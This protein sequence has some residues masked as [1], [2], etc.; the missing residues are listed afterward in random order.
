MSINQDN[1]HRTLPVVRQFLG[2]E[3]LLNLEPPYLSKA[4]VLDI[5]SQ[6]EAAKAWWNDV[7]QSFQASPDLPLCHFGSMVKHALGFNSFIRFHQAGLSQGELLSTME[8]VQAAFLDRQRQRKTQDENYVQWHARVQEI[9]NAESETSKSMKQI[10]M[11]LGFIGH[12]GPQCPEY[13]SPAPEEAA[14]LLRSLTPE[15]WKR[16]A[17][18][19]T[20]VKIEDKDLD[21]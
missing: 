16:L 20:R 18:G 15:V 17:H 14:Q 13:T 21:L 4:E 3:R 8:R 12:N 6:N 10:T 7:M 2:K 9:L 19:T 5:L 11:G 1:P